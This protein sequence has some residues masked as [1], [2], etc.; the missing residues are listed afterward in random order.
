M[1]I[2]E[3]INP[4]KKKTCDCTTRAIA[5]ASGV[6]WFEVLDMQYNA[7]KS[8]GYAFNDNPVLD[9]VCTKLGFTTVKLSRPQK[10]EKRPTVADIAEA[11]KNKRVICR[12]AGHLTAIIDGNIYDLWD[13]SNKAV[14]GYYI[15]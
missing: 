9:E 15:K 6:S 5:K 10:G 11:H 8:S 2:K 1:F 13:C 12:V 14:Y 3:N 7:S 4:F